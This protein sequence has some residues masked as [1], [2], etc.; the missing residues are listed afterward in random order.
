MHSAGIIC[1]GDR[2][3]RAIDNVWKA[4]RKL[5]V[6]FTR[7]LILDTIS[8]RSGYSLVRKEC[9]VARRYIWN[10]Q[11]LPT[12][13]CI[14][15][16]PEGCVGAVRFG[17]YGAT[18]I[19][20]LFLLKLN[21]WERYRKIPRHNYIAPL[22]FWHCW[23]IC[24]KIMSLSSIEQV[25]LF[26]CSS[27]VWTL[28]QRRT[29]K[30]MIHCFSI[31]PIMTCGERAGINWAA[32]NAIPSFIKLLT[33][34]LTQIVPTLRYRYVIHSLEMTA[35]QQPVVWLDDAASASPVPEVYEWSRICSS[36]WMQLQTYIIVACLTFKLDY[37]TPCQLEV[38]IS[39]GLKSPSFALMYNQ[40][41]N[42]NSIS[43]NELSLSR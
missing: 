21:N 1:S 12:D 33:L 35:T 16:V 30:N 22:R 32:R 37:K 20:L 38:T 36:T 3:A 29:N 17:L 5:Q 8:G 34:T 15:G 28:T 13:N 10:T 31:S 18:R 14:A 26:W 19:M 23:E 27:S 7:V 2:I 43:R 39:T 6:G 41:T 11:S 40:S 42:P 9:A 24:Y 25:T 4:V